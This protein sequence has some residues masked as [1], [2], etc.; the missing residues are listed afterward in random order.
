VFRF[1]KRKVE[2][3]IIL[4]VLVLSPLFLIGSGLAVVLPALEIFW[5]ARLA[6]AAGIQVTAGPGVDAFS[7]IPPNALGISLVLVGFTISLAVQY[8]LACVLVRLTSNEITSHPAPDRPRPQHGIPKQRPAAE[9][10]DDV[11]LCPYCSAAM[12]RDA[13]V[14]PECGRDWRTGAASRSNV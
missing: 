10:T 7:L 1:T 8:A 13:T 12:P 2:V 4:V 3:W 11:K 14:C 5:L 6:Q 9:G